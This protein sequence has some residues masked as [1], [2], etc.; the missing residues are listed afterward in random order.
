MFLF[1]ITINKQQA[2]HDASK[3]IHIYFHN[4]C[5]CHYSAQF[6]DACYSKENK[7]AIKDKKN[8]VNHVVTY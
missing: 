7:S 4:K 2:Q 3:L 5:V 6:T 8:K 1:S